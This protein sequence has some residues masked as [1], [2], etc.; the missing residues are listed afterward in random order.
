VIPIVPWSL[1]H[2]TGKAAFPDTIP[3]ETPPHPLLRFKEQENVCVS[4]QQLLP[5]GHHD[6]R[7]LS[8]PLAGEIVFQMDQAA[9]QN[10]GLLWHYR[11]CSQNSDL[12]RHLGLCARGYREENLESGP[13]SLHNSTDSEPDP[14]RKK[15]K[16]NLSS[17]FKYQLHNPGRQSQQP[18]ESIQLTIEQ[19]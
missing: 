19:V 4:D 14:F 2:W 5:A 13:K 12:D 3:G 10:Q 1:K 9:S 18:I 15:S 6:C 8:L 11:E 7:S 16:I 17:T